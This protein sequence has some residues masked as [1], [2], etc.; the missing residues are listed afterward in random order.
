MATA[1][2]TPNSMATDEPDRIS[3][4]VAAFVARREAGDAIRPEAFAEDARVPAALRQE[5]IEACESYLAVQDFAVAEP[6]TAFAEDPVGRMIGDY[7]IEAEID[8]GGMGIVYRAHQV[9]LDRRAAIKILPHFLSVSERHVAKFENE[10]RAV[11]KLDHPRIIK[12]FGAG[13]SRGGHHY[14][15]MEFVDGHTLYAELVALRDRSPVAARDRDPHLGGADRFRNA[16][17]LIAETAEGLA[18]AHEQG[19]IHR[20]VQ[21]RN[22]LLDADGNPK[23]IDFGLAK[24][25]DLESLT[26]SG[27]VAGVP[28]YMSPEQVRAERH[29]VDNRTDVYSLGVVF[30]ELLTLKRPFDGSTSQQVMRAIEDRTP[31]RP[32]E[33]DPTI[34]VA[35]ETVCLAAMEKERGHRLGSADRV[36]A[37]LRRYLAGEPL[38]IRPPSIPVRI[39]RWA[40]KRRAAL[41]AAAAAAAALAFGIAITRTP[42]PTGTLT[43]AGDTIRGGA[44]TIRRVEV[45]RTLELGPPQALGTAPIRARIVTAGTYRVRVSGTEGRSVELFGSLFE[46]DQQVTIGRVARTRPVEAIRAAFD[47]V[48]IP[49]GTAKIGTD[50]ELRYHGQE[51]REVTHGAFLIMRYEVRNSEYL[52]FLQAVGGELPKTWPPEWRNDLP[53]EARNLPVAGISH[54]GARAFASWHGMRLPTRFEW[55]IAARGRNGWLLPWQAAF[56]AETVRARANVGERS[57]ELSNA[58]PVESRPEGRSPFGLHHTVGNV[59]EWVEGVA[60]GIS[61]GPAREIPTYRIACGGAWFIAAENASVSNLTE[62]PIGQA[63]PTVGFRCVRSLEARE[64]E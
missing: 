6:E 33:V 22:I 3:E 25:L 54:D 16:A 17:R 42:T 29:A 46:E 57:L 11:A 7:R 45:P 5:V 63:G 10:A 8:R 15:A 9:S 4:Y 50:R 26:R 55:E 60:L 49:A 53:D 56:D 2:K 12:V 37:E 52:E 28:Y 64:D 27:E 31:V 24:A 20:D 30:Y 43:I 58:E 41:T 48:E 39:G 61:T 40:R 59:Y 21:P 34:P 38:T 14:L 62:I 19:V 36:A 51:P 32:R 23:I 35:L 1:Q 13:K 47:M 18:H 44:V